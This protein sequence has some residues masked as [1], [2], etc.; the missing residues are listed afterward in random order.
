MPA[1]SRLP[2]DLLVQAYA[3]GYFPMPDSATG[4][5]HWYRPDPRAIFPLDGFHVSVSLKKRLKKEPFTITFDTAFTD[6]MKGCAARPDTWINDEFLAAYTKLH[7]LGIAHS[8]EV[9]NK[10][11][12][13]LVGGVYGLSLNGA[14]FAESKFHTE[15]DASKAALYF[16]VEKLRKQGFLLLEVQFMTPHLKSLGAVEISDEEYTKRLQEALSKTPSF[17]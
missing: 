9:W 3:S 13:K 7:T 10:K 15:T 1:I 8:V 16:L 17:G 11:T 2:P 14:F 6:V 5:I 12:Q 4:E